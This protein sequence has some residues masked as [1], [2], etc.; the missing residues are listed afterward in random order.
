MKKNNLILDQNYIPA[1]SVGKIMTTVNV[2][3]CIT[4]K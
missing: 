3:N 1:E 4:L 2:N